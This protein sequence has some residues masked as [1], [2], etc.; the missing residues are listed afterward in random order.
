MKNIL[1]K[2]IALAFGFLGTFA[3]VTLW[4]SHP[5]WAILL[6]VLTIDII[7]EMVKKE[8]TR[9]FDWLAIIILLVSS[10]FILIK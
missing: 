9:G 6:G 2:I 10:Y 7:I 5:V 4:Q 8:Y 3:I 1:R